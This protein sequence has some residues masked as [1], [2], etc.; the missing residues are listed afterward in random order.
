MRR[1]SDL[2]AVPARRDTPSAG[3]ASPVTTLTGSP[4]QRAIGSRMEH[5]HPSLQTY[6]STIPEGSVGIGEGEFECFGTR[7]RWL[8]PVFALLRRRGVIVPGMHHHVP[9]RVENRTVAGQAVARR[10]VQ[11][12]NGDW[13]M[14]DAV[15][16]QPPARV[17]D[18]LGAPA[19]A[20]VTFQV[21]V[22]DGALE[23]TSQ[24]MALR[25]GRVRIPVPR[26]LAARV[27]LTERFDETTG[28]QRVDLTVDAPI[29]GRVYEYRGSFTYRIEDDR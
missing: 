28:R 19:T 7:H 5:L 22:R 18:V 29:L 16:F 12:T 9:F 15:S 20:E 1:C 27:R 21:G 2:P 13:T 11:L 6:F 25:L 14:T 26:P 3:Y 17:V 23:L 4:Y 10:T 8:T 24:G